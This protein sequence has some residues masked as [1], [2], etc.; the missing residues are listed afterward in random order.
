MNKFLVFSIPI[1]IFLSLYFS[2]FWNPHAT[3]LGG[4]S[5]VITDDKILYLTYDDGPGEDTEAMVS[6][7]KKY[8]VHATF[9]IT[10][11]QAEKNPDLIKL[12][13]DN[14]HIIANHGY[15]HKFLWNKKNS[16]LVQ[17]GKET[18]ESL[19]NQS[20]TLFRPPYGF[21]SPVT[22]MQAKRT[23]QTLVL[24]GVIT[25]DYAGIPPEKIAK[26]VIKKFKPGLIICLHDG[27]EN[28]K[29]TVVATELII[30]EAQAQ[31][32]RFE[33]LS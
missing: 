12:L 9:F 29:N 1:L 32:Y 23:N 24:W 14:N 8:G 20:I 7:L 3:I 4:I 33:V 18:L 5:R 28:R 21:R 13:L 17:K 22:Y 25:R 6:L 27:P 26:K 2:L 15:E 10:G 19:T 16:L 31:G 11:T 30:R